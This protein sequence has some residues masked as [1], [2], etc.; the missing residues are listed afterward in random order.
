MG[1][2]GLLRFKPGN[3][4]GI[5][6]FYTKAIFTYRMFKDAFKFVAVVLPLVDTTC[7]TGYSAGWFFPLIGGIETSFEL[8]SVEEF[9]LRNKS[10]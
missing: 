8:V 1:F 6:I 9:Q 3:R 5:P 10:V 2:K 4:T 7:R